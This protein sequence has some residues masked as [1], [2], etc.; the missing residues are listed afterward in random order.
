[1]GCPVNRRLEKYCYLLSVLRNLCRT[2]SRTS[3]RH[4]HSRS[5]CHSGHG[6]KSLSTI[7][8]KELRVPQKEWSSLIISNHRRECLH[9]LDCLHRQ[10]PVVNFSGPYLY[11]YRSPGF[12][13]ADE[14]REDSWRD[15]LVQRRHYL[16]K[17]RAHRQ[18]GL[19]RSF[20]LPLL[21]QII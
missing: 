5:W 2:W 3:M 4:H 21:A 13:R 10:Q 9:E 12:F 14:W 18:R 15:C 7:E 1:M 20:L 8:S 19:I 16:F 11:Y 17:Y 6:L